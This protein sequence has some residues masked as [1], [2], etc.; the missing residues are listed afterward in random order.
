MKAEIVSVGTEIL[1][2]QIAD[3]NAQLLGETLA[4]AGVFHYHRQTVG[5]HLERLTAALE[6]ALSRADIVF[7]IGGLGPTMDDLTRNAIAKVAGEELVE[8]PAMTAHIREIFDRRGLRWRDSQVRQA[9]KPASASFLRNPN[10]TAPGLFCKIGDKSVIALPGPRNE[11]GP[12]LRELESGFLR[13]LH[14]DPLRTT[15]LRIVGIGESEVERRLEDLML[16]SHPTVAPYAK[17]GE[18]HIRV[19]SLEGDP[20]HDVVLAEIR[21]RLTNHVYGEGETT[22]EESVIQLLRQRSATLGVAES[23]TGGGLGEAITTVSGGSDIFAGGVIAYHPEIKTRFLNVSNEIIDT[24][25]TVSEECAVA[26]AVGAR[27]SLGVTYAVS[28]T[29]VAGEDPITENGAIKPSGLV[30][31]AV[32]GPDGHQVHRF[33]LAGNRATIRLRATRLALQCL[34]DALL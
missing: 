31:V 24:V 34:R 1:L 8:D 22:L 10:G 27:E 30:F 25:G 17:V 26:M 3:T 16:A 20:N 4:N 15:I 9:M 23:C 5:D 2:G 32:A 33:Q 7:T 14:Q 21:E 29:G 11:F 28:T 13:G 19:T 6:L 18:V 12:M